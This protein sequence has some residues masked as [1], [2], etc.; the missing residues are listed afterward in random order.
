MQ[1]PE[2]RL[3]PTAGLSAAAVFHDLQQETLVLAA[4]SSPYYLIP[5]IVCGWLCVFW[6]FVLVLAEKFVS[7]T[8]CA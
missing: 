5:T 2:G 4:Q 6:L 7:E 1:V 8:F 3:L